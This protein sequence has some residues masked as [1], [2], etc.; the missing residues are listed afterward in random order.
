RSHGLADTRGTRRE[1]AAVTRAI[2]E[3][4]IVRRELHGFGHRLRDWR[5]WVGLRLPREP[6]EWGLPA[7]A[8]FALAPYILWV[9]LLVLGRVDPSLKQYADPG[10]VFEVFLLG[11]GTY[12]CA[13]A[14][15]IGATTVTREREQA[16]W[17]QVTVTPMTASELVLGYWLARALPLAIGVLVSLLTW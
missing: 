15:V 16:T 8:W 9:L 3:N 13:V 5:L 14:T 12:A 11:L 1:P 4:P 2:W 6:R 10:T 7:I 17:E